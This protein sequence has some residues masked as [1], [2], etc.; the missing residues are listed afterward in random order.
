MTEREV[1][2]LETVIRS[3]GESPAAIARQT[4]LSL[5]LIEPILERLVQLNYVS[6]TGASYQGIAR[7]GGP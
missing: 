7:P 5:R 6:R 4:G 2:V 1:L 3:G